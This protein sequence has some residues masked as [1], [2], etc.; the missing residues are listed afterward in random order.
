MPLLFEIDEDN[1]KPYEM[2]YNQI[3]QRIFYNWNANEQDDHFLW[4]SVFDIEKFAEDLC[5]PEGEA[6]PLIRDVLYTL[7]CSDV[8]KPS[9]R[10]GNLEH[11]RVPKGSARQFKEKFIWGLTS[12]PVAPAKVTTDNNKPSKQKSRDLSAAVLALLNENLRTERR[13]YLTLAQIEEAL[14][15]HE[16][17]GSI[18]KCM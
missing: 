4:I 15:S 17:S 12:A 9:F 14:D 16:T 18:T 3:L 2:L 11:R 7:G 8:V 13:L 5:Y 10:T 1:P 6:D